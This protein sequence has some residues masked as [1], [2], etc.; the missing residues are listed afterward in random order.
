MKSSEGTNQVQTS[1]GATIL[2]QVE[3][4]ESLT[5]QISDHLNAI[6]GSLIE[7][8]VSTEAPTMAGSAGGLEIHKMPRRLTLLE[9]LTRTNEQSMRIIAQLSEINKNLI[10]HSG[11]TYKESDVDSSTNGQ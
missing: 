5:K 3:L 10:V 4:H 2:N 8:G 11:M 9:R 1:T 6:D 7:L